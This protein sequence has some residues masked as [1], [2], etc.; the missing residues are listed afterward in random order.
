[1]NKI[2]SNSAKKRRRIYRDHPNL[3]LSQQEVEE[4]GK[5]E[6]KQNQKKRKKE[7]IW[8]YTIAVYI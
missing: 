5:Q 1:M 7:R 6:K 4:I 8:R 3:D 2:Y